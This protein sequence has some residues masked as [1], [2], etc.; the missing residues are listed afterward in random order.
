MTASPV[1]ASC[2]ASLDEVMQ[3]MEEIE[4]R[5]LPIVDGE[6]LIGV[7][8]NRDLFGATGWLP[9]SCRVNESPGQA[10]DLLRK[11]PIHCSPDDSVVMVAVDLS[12][13]VIGC[14]PV[15]EEGKLVGIVT[16]MDMLEAYID[17]CN[18]ENSPVQLH[19]PVA[20]HMTAPVSILS[21]ESTL[22]QALAME[23]DRGVRHLPI[24]ED[25]LLVGIIS[26]R[27]LLKAVGR[28]KIESTPVEHLMSLSP[29]TVEPDD[30]L[31]HAASCLLEGKISALPVVEDDHLVG[32]ITLTD[33]LEYCIA[34]L[35]NPDTYLENH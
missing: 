27:D 34:N 35:R 2:N 19:E 4:A 5:H 11:R 18:L 15:L 32:I 30:S 31:S 25:G 8:S 6:E 16:E 21:P 12:S 14:L 20:D 28:L 24:V 1:T 10:K 17:L 33:M 13:R 3:A 9:Q 29:L 26:D 23:R 22:G 7:L